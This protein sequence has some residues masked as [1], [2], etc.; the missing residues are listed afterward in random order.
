MKKM[1][2]II[3][4][5]TIVVSGAVWIG[6]EGFRKKP[7]PITV[8]ILNAAYDL[9]TMVASFKNAMTDLGYTENTD[10]HYI[11]NGYARDMDAL[12]AAIDMMTEKKPDLIFTLT[13]PVTMKAKKAFEGSKV[14]IVFA[15]V[16]DPVGAGFVSS[17]K[18][19]G[20]NLTGIQAGSYELKGLEW[21]L[22]VMPDLKRI[23]V[24][25]NPDDRA[26]V[27]TLKLL[28]KA[29]SDRHV[30][31]VVATARSEKDLSNAIKKMPEDVQAVWQLPS[32]SYD[33]DYEAVILSVIDQKKPLISHLQTWVEKGALI[34]SGASNEALGKQA[35]RLVDKIL[36]GGSTAVI[37]V[38]R[39]EYF[40]HI[41][42]K[43]AEA[44]SV[45]IP[46][47]VIKQSHTIIR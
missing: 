41:N 17:L 30:E 8:G 7:K 28:K 22:K 14:P 44:I 21:L 15:L 5:I 19:P 27:V 33:S 9:E 4:V 12:D 42:L 45:E 32:P 29:A 1:S 35:G 36:Q 31:L 20:G 11:Y 34:S 16:V 47:S 13:T 26:M 23:Y 40:L 6:L 10:I 25:F 38:E 37:P 18:R 2:V 24:P 3:A 43:T 46:D 39:V